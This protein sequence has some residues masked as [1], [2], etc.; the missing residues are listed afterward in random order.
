M[1]CG[2][3][4][5]NT[6]FLRLISCKA[7]SP[8]WSYSR[9]SR[10]SDDLREAI[11]P[12]RTRPSRKSD[13]G[14]TEYRTL[15]P[16]AGHRSRRGETA[17]CFAFSPRKRPGWLNSS[18]ERLNPARDWKAP[19]TRRHGPVVEWPRSATSQTCCWAAALRGQGPARRAHARR[20]KQALA[21]C[22]DDATAFNNI[23]VIL[24]KLKRF[25]SA[26]RYAIA[27]RRDRLSHL[28]ERISMTWA[29]S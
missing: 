18:T 27:G 25:V 22:P 23:G 13:T 11:R 8:P 16:R 15:S 5:F 21:V 24:Q 17:D 28:T 29:A 20:Y 12:G 19:E 3:R 10:S 9:S 7:S 6:G 26:L 1:S 14:A 4:F 2:T